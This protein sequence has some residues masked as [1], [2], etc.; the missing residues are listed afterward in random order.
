[1][2]LKNKFAFCLEAL[3]GSS[4]GDLLA[5]TSGYH[6]YEPSPFNYRL[7]SSSILDPSATEFQMENEANF[8]SNYQPTISRSTD[9]S[10]RRLSRSVNQT[11]PRFPTSCKYHLTTYIQ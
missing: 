10:H 5:S 8:V 7:K 11:V 6:S 3:T 2:L 9:P 1:M 4:S